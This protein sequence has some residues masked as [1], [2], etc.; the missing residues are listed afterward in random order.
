MS[1]F[2]E[3]RCLKCN[4][5]GW[6][7][8]GIIPTNYCGVSTTLMWGHPCDEC[9]DGWKEINDTDINTDFENAM[10]EGEHLSDLKTNR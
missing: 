3:C 4:S 7:R 10:A 2:K 8:T 6:N 9:I 5:S 1:D